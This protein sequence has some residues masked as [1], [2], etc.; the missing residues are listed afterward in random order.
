VS[1]LWRDQIQVY[2]APERIDVVR[3][4][5]GFKPVQA[6]K[7]TKS[8][9]KQDADQPLWAPPMQQLAQMLQD[10]AGVEMTITISNHFVRYVTLPPLAE[11]TTPDE[12]SAYAAFRM[13][14]VYAGR[15]DD[16]ALS[17]SAWDPIDGAICAAIP[18][19]LLAKFEALAAQ[20]K[21]KL[22]DVE[23]YFASVYD[24]WHKTLV[25]TKICFAVI[26][27]GRICIA[28]LNNG[29]WQ[30]IRNQRVSH[31]IK[32]ELRIALDQ[33]AILSGN[34]QAFEQVYLF[35]PEHP[36]LSLPEDCGWQITL[37]QTEQIPVLAH[38]PSPIVNH[39][40]TSECVA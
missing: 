31:D 16:W 27:S 10:T 6:P 40:E 38:Y 8:C 37:L 17:I 39:T 34:K 1:P 12:V 14:E 15:V 25:N 7:I 33:E 23:P 19:D 22:K 18:R 21:I 20:H 4:S 29:V 24:R 30:S 9:Q 28:L 32:D 5:R 35:A 13:R 36:D 3:T 2:F 11:I 26:E